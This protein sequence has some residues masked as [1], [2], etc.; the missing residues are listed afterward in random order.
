MTFKIRIK[1]NNYRLFKFQ[2][3]IDDNFEF[4]ANCNYL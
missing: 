1:D 3:K 4:N 2:N